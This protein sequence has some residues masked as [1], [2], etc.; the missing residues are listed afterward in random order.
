MVEQRR[1][2]GERG[3]EIE[4]ASNNPRRIRIGG[5]L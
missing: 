4:V 5:N 2:C 1:A 3:T